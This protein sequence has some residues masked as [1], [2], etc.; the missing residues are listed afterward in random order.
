MKSLTIDGVSVNDPVI[1][2]AQIARGVNVVF[3]MSDSPQAWGSPTITRGDNNMGAFSEE[4]AAGEGREEG[5]ERVVE[6]AEL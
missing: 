2:H 6:R 3:E 4:N 1:T 5:S